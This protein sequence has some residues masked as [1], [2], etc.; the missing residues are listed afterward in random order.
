MFQKQSKY[1][2]SCSGNG[3]H[4]HSDY[5]HHAIHD[6]INVTAGEWST[7]KEN[8]DTNIKKARESHEKVQPL[9]KFYEVEAIKASGSAA[10][11]IKSIQS[12]FKFFE[13]TYDEL[14]KHYEKLEG[15]LEEG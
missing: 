6:E 15:Y 12:D 9:I 7:L 10:K 14:M 2:I 11:N 1:C 4:R 13:K 5:K 8:F 3:T